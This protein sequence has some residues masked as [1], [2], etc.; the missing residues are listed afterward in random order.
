MRLQHIFLGYE[1]HKAIIYESYGKNNLKRNRN[2]H[3]TSKCDCMNIKNSGD[4]DY[5]SFDPL[6]KY[7]IECFKCK[8]IGH[9]SC[10]CK[11][12]KP[13]IKEST[14]FIQKEKQN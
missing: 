6:Q 4:R 10:N 12:I 11:L 2:P 13:S 3:K 7:N 1:L 8:N 5:N 14:I 9:K